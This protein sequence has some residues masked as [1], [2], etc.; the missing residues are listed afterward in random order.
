MT[1]KGFGMVSRKHD[2]KMLQSM[3]MLFTYTPV[4]KQAQS[5]TASGFQQAGM[6]SSSDVIA[7]VFVFLWLFLCFKAC[8]VHV[9][10]LSDHPERLQLWTLRLPAEALPL[11]QWTRLLSHKDGCL[12]L[13]LFPAG[14][15]VTHVGHPSASTLLLLHCCTYAFGAAV[16]FECF[17]GTLCWHGQ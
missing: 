10:S 17:C 5:S 14:Q 4:E 7:R 11:L 15:R 3:P 2:G 13:D 1:D 12:F 8:T 9:N 16:T 6:M